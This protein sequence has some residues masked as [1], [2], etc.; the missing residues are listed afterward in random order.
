VTTAAKAPERVALYP[1]SFDPV[2]NGHLDL[3]ERALSI[4]DRLV[5]AV[6]VNPD[7]AGLFSIDERCDLL[8]ESVRHVFGD[9]PRIEVDS[10][11]GLLVHYAAARG[12]RA[13]IRGLRAVSDFEYEF[14]MANMNRTLNREVDF[15]FLMTGE[16]NFYVSSR[17]IREVARFGGNVTGLVPEPVVRRLEEK[18]RG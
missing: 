17:L 2:T 14:H 9:E 1:G 8:R 3:V 12:I 18:Y 4:F 11:E 7:K 10:F 6:A 13:I 5:I 16:A 15:M